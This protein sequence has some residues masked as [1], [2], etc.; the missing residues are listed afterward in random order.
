MKKT[1]KRYELLEGMTIGLE[2]NLTSDLCF[3]LDTGMTQDEYIKWLHEDEFMSE[4]DPEGPLREY[5][6]YIYGSYLSLCN[7]KYSK[8]FEDSINYVVARWEE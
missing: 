6:G 3:I 7:G 2:K 5:V 1:N 4:P 8:Y